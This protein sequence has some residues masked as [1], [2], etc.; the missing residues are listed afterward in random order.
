[1]FLMKADFEPVPNEASFWALCGYAHYGYWHQ[2][3][4]YKALEYS[5]ESFQ[6]ALTY[7][8]N[9]QEKYL[10]ASARIATQ[11]GDYDMALQSLAAYITEY[12]TGVDL[13]NVT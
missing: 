2:T 8:S 6:I 10:L 13:K 12:P 9:I 11:W 1:M 5:Y 4:S 3:R 7:A